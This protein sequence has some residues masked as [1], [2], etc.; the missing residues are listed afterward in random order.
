MLTCSR[1]F[2]SQV[3]SSILTIV[4]GHSTIGIV[5][6]GARSLLWLSSVDDI[7]DII[8]IINWSSLCARS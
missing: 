6:V 3:N 8:V 7:V 4:V 1:F 5:V 2:A